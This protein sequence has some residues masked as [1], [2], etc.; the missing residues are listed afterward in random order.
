MI[1]LKNIAYVTGMIGMIALMLLSCL[2][3]PLVSWGIDPWH[4]NL[5]SQLKLRSK[6]KN[7]RMQARHRAQAENQVR[8]LER[9]IAEKQEGVQEHKAKIDGLTGEIKELTKALANASEYLD[10]LQKAAKDESSS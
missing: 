2:F 3:F 7:D 6:M 5:I 1:V 8:H 4:E 10:D 9:L